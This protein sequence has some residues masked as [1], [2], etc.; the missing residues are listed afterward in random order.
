MTTDKK[1]IYIVDDDESVCRALK[2]LLM[3]F[4]FEVRAFNSAKEF[5]N[6]V[7]IEDPGCLV[8]DI[9]MSGMDGWETQRRILAS[10][11]K[12]PVIFVS[13]AKENVSERALEVGAVGF[14]QKP[15]DGQTLVDLINRASDNL[16]KSQK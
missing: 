10:G 13:A 2:S 9:H 14:L 11:S 3:T 15:F 8:L 4:D 16:S 6:N 5:F 12:R 1:Q 7:S